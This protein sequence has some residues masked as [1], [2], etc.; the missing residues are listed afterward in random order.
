MLER[1]LPTCLQFSPPS[2]PSLSAHTP[3]DGLSIYPLS[4]IPCS[5]CSYPSCHQLYKSVWQVLWLSKEGTGFLGG[6][7]WK[8]KRL[9]IICM[10]RGIPMVHRMKGGDEQLVS[11]WH[12][13]AGEWVSWS[14]SP[15]A[16][17]SAQP[18]SALM[19]HGGDVSWRCWQAVHAFFF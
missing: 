15:Y 14:Y 2:H 7:G 18:L 12:V 5:V 13:L 19:G 8:S 1:L 11:V 6:A 3:I 16:V 10:G 4:P 17:W 9:R